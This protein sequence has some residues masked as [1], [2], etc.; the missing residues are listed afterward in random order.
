M[1]H[2]ILDDSSFRDIFKQRIKKLYRLSKGRE[3]E[4]RSPK[5]YTQ[6]VYAHLLSLLENLNMISSLFIRFPSTNIFSSFSLTYFSIN[7]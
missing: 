2:F 3:F 5:A 7:V 1:K 6:R 4:A